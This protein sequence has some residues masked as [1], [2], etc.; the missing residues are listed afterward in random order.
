M[1]IALGIMYRQHIA[2]KNATL[3]MFMSSLF[4]LVGF[5]CVGVRL[6]FKSAFTVVIYTSTNSNN[7]NLPRA[8]TK[9]V[10]QPQ[11]ISFSMLHGKTPVTETSFQDVAATRSLL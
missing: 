8:F 4:I 7:Y 6:C 9:F 2:R 11:N 10:T 5:I 3:F 1:C